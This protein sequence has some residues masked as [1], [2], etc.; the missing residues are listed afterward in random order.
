MFVEHLIHIVPHAAGD[1]ILGYKID[2]FL[3]Q[4]PHYI[5]GQDLRGRFYGV[6]VNIVT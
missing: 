3:Q 1:W 6:V 5:I 4:V 2:I